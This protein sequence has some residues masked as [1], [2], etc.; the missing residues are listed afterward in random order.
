MV[1]VTASEIGS[2]SAWEIVTAAAES[3]AACLSADY[4]L[5]YPWMDCGPFADWDCV[6]PFVGWDC[7]Y[8]FLDWDCVC[9]WEDSGLSYAVA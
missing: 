1:R 8:P 3:R 2:G 7:A 6:C 5:A 4:D 9:L